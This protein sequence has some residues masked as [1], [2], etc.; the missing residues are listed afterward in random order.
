[1]KIFCKISRY[2]FSQISD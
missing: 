2:L 1:M